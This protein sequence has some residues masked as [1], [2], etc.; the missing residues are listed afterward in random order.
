MTTKP[1]II[2]T[3]GSALALA[4]SR[5]VAAAIEAAHPGV[6]V[7]L[8][9]ISTKGDRVLDVSLHKVGDKG[10]FTAELEEALLAGTADIAVHSMKDL[11]TE[12]PTG[13]GI[14]AV[15]RRE[16]PRDAVIL[17]TDLAKELGLL[18][19]RSDGSAAMELL[20]EGAV[21]GTSSLRRKAAVLAWRPDADVRDLRGNVDTRLGK[22]ANGDFDAILLAAAGMRRLGFLSDASPVLDM[23]KYSGE[24][25]A[26][27]LDTEDCVPAA[28]Q[29]AVAIE[30]RVGD[31]AV[32]ALLAPLH[33]ERTAGACTAER[34][35]LATLGG[36]CQVPAGAHASIEDGRVSL[37]C[38]LS[39]PDGAQVL[40]ASTTVALAVA[41]TMAR[42]VAQSLLDRG[43][44][45]IIEQCRLHG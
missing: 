33:C 8:N 16:D 14:G 7:E 17:R 24:L 19:E 41:D 23:P 28:C 38:V 3:R 35:F 32:A 12:L 34:A 4:Q 21:I 1:I 6:K 13:L 43:G 31:A 44:R 25:A 20:A 5:A 9:I 18:D 37:S 36:G 42:R 39:S 45:E 15:C 27:L 2:A 30:S 40:S 29:G 26:F 11:P 22:L 10:L